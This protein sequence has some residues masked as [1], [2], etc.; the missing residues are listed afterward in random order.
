M[1]KSMNIRRTA[2]WVI[3]NN[4]AYKN[5]NITPK[6]K[7]QIQCVIDYMWSDKNK[8]NILE[9]TRC[10]KTMPKMI[11]A[12]IDDLFVRRLIRKF[13]HTKGTTLYG[14]LILYGKKGYEY[15]DNYCEKQAY[16]N[17]FDYKKKKYN[18]T[19]DQ[20]DEYNKNRACT[21]IN[22]I[23]R[24]GEIEGTKKWDNYC[25]RQSYTNTL[26]YQIEKYNGDIDKATKKMRKI[27]SQKGITYDN[28]MRKYGDREK[29]LSIL[30]NKNV[31]PGFVSRGSQDLF[32]EIYSK[33]L[34]KLRDHC[35]FADIRGGKEF[36]K[37][38]NDN[39]KYYFYDFVISNI[40]LCIEFNGDCWHANPDRYTPNEYINIYK[41]FSDV[42]VTAK[43]IWDND[44]KKN[45]V[46]KDEGFNVI[47]VW[48]S[49]W[50]ND[51]KSVI[52]KCLKVI[53]DRSKE[54]NI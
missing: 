31:N 4:S 47:I 34:D 24:H 26:D 30:S 17:S 48:E 9:N 40:K 27:N 14:M 22:L 28:L 43:E 7:E 20:F 41:A 39:K 19:K 10:K 52:D 46:L 33:L 37:I 12:G 36:G 49:D 2:E 5:L 25:K 3:N 18:W 35:Y 50:N 51:N 32:H 38:S 8:D 23:K 42:D 54:Y 11:K 15:W 6:Q 13:K 53:N 21:K 45:K 16:T 44:K 1:T 29:V